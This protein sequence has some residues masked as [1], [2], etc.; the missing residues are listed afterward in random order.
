MF[1]IKA[2]AVGAATATANPAT[3]A[4]PGP[5]DAAAEPATP[6][7]TATDVAKVAAVAVAA[8]VPSELSAVQEAA[9]SEALARLAAQPSVKRAFVSRVEGGI[10]I[11]SLAIRDLATGELAIPADRL[12]LRDLQT[13]ILCLEGS[14]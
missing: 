1:S 12:D 5:I 10:A 4:T 3:S 14:T 2:L 7:T 9:R 11:I 6:A 13:L 8:G